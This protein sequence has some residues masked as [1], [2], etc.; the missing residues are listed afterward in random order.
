MCGILFHRGYIPGASHR[1]AQIVVVTRET[2]KVED[3]LYRVPRDHFERQSDV[4]RDLFQLPIPAGTLPDGSSDEQ[5]LL[6]E[7]ICKEDFK[8]LLRIMFPT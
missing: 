3:V 7:G 6:L 8:Q 1:S 4:F 5:P 2:R